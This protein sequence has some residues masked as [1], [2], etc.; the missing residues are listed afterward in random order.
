V[1]IAGDRWALVGESEEL[2]VRVDRAV[3]L[4][5]ERGVR[6]DV[7]VHVAALEGGHDVGGAV[8]VRAA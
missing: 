2:A 8:Q 7:R 6:G 4:L 3:G 1:V 5:G